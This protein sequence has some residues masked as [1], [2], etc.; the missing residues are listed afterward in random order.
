MTSKSKA[1]TDEFVR[2]ELLPVGEVSIS[3]DSGW[4]PLDQGRV[5]E[6]V[7]DFKDGAYGQNTLAPPS[8]IDGGVCASDGKRRLD[9]GLQSVAALQ[10]LLG[11]YQEAKANGEDV[12]E[13]C[14]CHSLL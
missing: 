3:K 12:P 4:R 9:N 13:T 1:K 7:A 2:S 5:Q 11:E 6:L 8:I 10:I 14:L